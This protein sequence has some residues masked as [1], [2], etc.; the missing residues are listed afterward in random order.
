MDD[1]AKRE[2]T[3]GAD[4]QQDL[5][6]WAQIIGLLAIPVVIPAA[7]Y[8]IQ[9][10]GDARDRAE[11]VANA[12]SEDAMK[13]V[14]VFHKLD[15][16]L[17]DISELYARGMTAKL[18]ASGAVQNFL[19]LREEARAEQTRMAAALETHLLRFE[20]KL[21]PDVLRDFGEHAR[22]ARD[23]VMP[24]IGDCIDEAYLHILSGESA[25]PAVDACNLA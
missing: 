7:L 1:D 14:V 2:A 23:K 12:I 16:A 20:G 15:L 4:G 22:T 6:I 10:A 25:A 21:S 5:P 11:T 17:Q 9:E 8:W 18:D 24:Q 19:E 13:G 3:V